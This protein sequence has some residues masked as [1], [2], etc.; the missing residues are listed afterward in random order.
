VN[1]LDVTA[2]P[3]S[4]PG[5]EYKIL[6]RVIKD[7]APTKDNAGNLP[8]HPL[9]CALV[10]GGTLVAGKTTPASLAAASI[11]CINTAQSSVS[12]YRK[13][14]PPRRCQLSGSYVD[15]RRTS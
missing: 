14:A 6:C 4:I 15:C 7:G 9:L 13:G 3:P 1:C 8:G 11:V 2:L 10:N 12:L 5:G